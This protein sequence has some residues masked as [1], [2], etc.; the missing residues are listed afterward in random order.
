MAMLVLLR[1]IVRLVVIADGAKG[2]PHSWRRSSGIAA[3]RAAISSKALVG[4][5]QGSPPLWSAILPDPSF[6]SRGEKVSTALAAQR[7][8]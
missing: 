8:N 2:N 5:E 6:C 7:E 4:E 3:S 1:M